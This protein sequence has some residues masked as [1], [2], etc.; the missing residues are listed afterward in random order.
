M[1]LSLYCLSLEIANIHH[2][3]KHNN[4]QQHFILRTEIWQTRMREIQVGEMV[5]FIIFRTKMNYILL[6]INILFY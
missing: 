2:E 6:F 3:K 1:S 5:F 4:H